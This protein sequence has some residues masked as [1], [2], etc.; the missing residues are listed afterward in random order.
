M[1]T[2]NFEK[3]SES[4]VN[5]SMMYAQNLSERKNIPNLLHFREILRSDFAKIRSE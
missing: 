2:S 1:M 3:R 5:M 4:D